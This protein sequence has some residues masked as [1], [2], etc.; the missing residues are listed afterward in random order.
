MS[1]LHNAFK[2]TRLS[3][4]LILC[5]LILAATSVY[6]AG[7]ERPLAAVDILG[8]PDAAV[9]G[10]FAVGTTTPGNKALTVAGVIDFVGAGT[11]HN[12]FTQGPGNN[13]Q[14]RSNVDE[15]NAVGN[16]SY[17]QW[18]MVM[19]A[20]LDVFS[21][22]RSPASGTYNEDALFWIEGDTGDVGIAKVDTSNGATIPFTLDARL[23]V[24]TD[25]G[26]AIRG[27]STATS[28]TTRG[29]YGLTENSSG[30]GVYG[31]STA[32][33]GSSYGVHGVSTS[34][35]GLGVYGVTTATAGS[36]YGVYGMISSTSGAA[37]GGQANATS[38]QTY[39][40]YMV[41]SSTEGTGVYG[42][43]TATAGF[44]YGVYGR[45]DSNTGRGVYGTAN[46]SG[47]VSCGVYG[48]ATASSG[49][50]YG[51]YG[52]S[53]SSA[54][55]GVT[56]WA[57]ATNGTTYGVYGQSDSNNGS[58]VYGLA[59]A[60]SGYTYGVYGLVDSSNGSGVYG[61]NTATSADAYGVRGES[62]ATG[63]VGVAGFAGDSGFA[64]GVYGYSASSGGFGVFGFTTAGDGVGGE[65]QATDG[66]GVSGNAASS[67]GTNY[68][69]YGRTSS[70]SGYAFYAAGSGT[71][72]GPFTGAHE[73]R[74][75]DSF[76]S[77]VKPGMIVSATGEAQF[78]LT[79]DGSVDIS[80]TLP[81]VKLADSAED[82]AVFGVLVSE[83][84]LPDDHWYAAQDGERFASVNALGEGRVWVTDING[85]IQ[86]GEYITTSAI[87]GY[88]QRQDGIQ[89]YSYTLAKA[90]ETVDWDTV[91]ETVIFNGQEYKIYLLA[92]VYTSG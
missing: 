86:A 54:G 12:Y 51:V 37:V 63:G 55:V 60:T 24:Q 34:T 78:R 5:V 89:L 49:T 22:R 13:M 1:K 3:I 15:Y 30:S 48:Y 87:P 43:T 36:T 38:G 57:S 31:E 9:D 42:H 56:G 47:G 33:S 8:S 16:S 64:R 75:S 6:A 26:D 73:V 17:A 2:T 27:E 77:D 35:S 85:G 80:S 65:S 76:P 83:V 44:T 39:G 74:L 50:N 82:I 29:V 46:A 19:G 68:G 52:R 41:N 67:T 45:S 53:L 84:T 25:T 40:L 20:S 4:W 90:T 92:V 62:S 71:D 32:S 66:R 88:G 28:G 72:Y 58:G 14:I 79:E 7:N 59:L 69:V 61:K 18:N 21:I 81:T 10:Q 11:V 23:H 70:T 91:S